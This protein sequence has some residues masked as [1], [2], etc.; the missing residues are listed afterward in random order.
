VDE[1]RHVLG[2]RESIAITERRAG[3]VGGTIAVAVIRAVVSQEW[4]AESPCGTHRTR[5][6]APERRTDSDAAAIRRSV[7]NAIAICQSVAISIG[8]PDAVPIA[9][10]EPVTFSVS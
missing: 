2:A 7:A 8:Q 10:R 1:R 6:A 4:C 5:R 9:K 3:S